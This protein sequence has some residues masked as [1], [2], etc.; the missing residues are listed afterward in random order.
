MRLWRDQVQCSTATTP[1]NDDDFAPAIA[2]LAAALFIGTP[3][4][5][6]TGSMAYNE[7]GAAL[8][9]A[10]II[11]AWDR[12]GTPV[13]RGIVIGLLSALA[14][15]SKLS[16]AV[17][18]LPPLLL[19]LAGL[20]LARPSAPT[21]HGVSV[22]HLR[23]IVTVAVAAISTASIALLPW[24]VRNA[25][26]TGNP[27]FPFATVVFGSGSW[28]TE[29]VEVWHHAHG[30]SGPIWQRLG[31]LW[32]QFFRF[33]IGS[34]PITAEPWRPF[35]AVLP[36]VAA[37]GT[38][39]LCLR[40]GTRRMGVAF[41]MAL[42]AAM[43]GWMLFTHMKSRFF[44]PMAPIAALAAALG[45]GAWAIRAAVVPVAALRSSRASR[46]ARTDGARA[47]DSASRAARA[48]RTSRASRVARA[49][50]LAAALLVSLQP[51]AAF[52]SE[53]PTASLMIGAERAMT[54]DELAERRAGE[55]AA[56]G[57]ASNGSAAPRSR[58]F[59]LNFEIAPTVAVDGA[60]VLLIGDAATFRYRVPL[61]SSTVWTRDP[62][63]SAIIAEESAIAVRRR[64]RAAGIGWVLVDPVMLSV[65]SRSGWLDPALSPESIRR[66]SAA[67]EQI[68]GP[69]DGAMLFRVP[70]D[71]AESAPLLR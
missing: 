55:R 26:A 64:L 21:H 8:A 71:P 40:R 39:V 48:A 25:I 60:R 51:I 45:C 27:F 44:V 70:D 20:D 54:G 65:W 6:V 32:D 63:V 7:M 53:G 43:L 58:A 31:H 62:I 28:S 67:L 69:D 1:P 3:W 66:V 19:L 36:W 56:D 17:M 68:R 11:A 24:L 29:Q 50:M 10:A 52:I 57:S 33:G 14:V 9:C 35:W 2:A 61:R 5:V 30:A 22:R 38:V 15:G 12:E 37:A 23:V 49:A 42:G 34:A 4:I 18:V 47:V 16:A 46:A 41:A 59:V 13:R